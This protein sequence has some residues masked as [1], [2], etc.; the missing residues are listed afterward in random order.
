M[1]WSELERLVMTAEGDPRLQ[2]KLRT[3]RDDAELILM[4]RQLGY[5]V[6]RL[7]LQRAIDD[8][9]ASTSPAHA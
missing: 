2:G 9:Q 7:D 3:C 4:A 6:T 8:H 5:R 1:S